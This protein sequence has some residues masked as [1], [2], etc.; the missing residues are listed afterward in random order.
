MLPRVRDLLFAHAA[1]LEARA[2]ARLPAPPRVLEIG[3]GMARAAMNLTRGLLLG[4]PPALLVSFGV[5]GAYPLRLFAA[6]SLS[7]GDVCVVTHDSFGD[8][9]VDT[10]TGFVSASTLGLYGETT[11]AAP[12]ELVARVAGALALP[13]V[14]GATV[15]TCCG[16]DARASAVAA[17]TGAAVET[18]EGAAVALVCARFGVPWLQ[19]RAVSNHC[20]DRQRAGFDLAR[21]LD[22]L[23]AVMPRVVAAAGPVRD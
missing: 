15:A 18:M 10:E 22:A 5:C 8:E 14:R 20:G 19:V 13:C 4:P 12:A 23:A 9:G 1:P 11:F 21:A 6:A 2:L 16:T 3:V 17:R 7:V